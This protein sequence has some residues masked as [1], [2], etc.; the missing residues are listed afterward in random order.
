MSN[1]CMYVWL[2][3]FYNSQMLIS[4]LFVSIWIHAWTAGTE[5]YEKVFLFS[6]IIYFL[7]QTEKERRKVEGKRATLYYLASKWSIWW[8]VWWV[9]LC[10]LC[11]HSENRKR[12]IKMMPRKQ[13]IFMSGERASDLRCLAMLVQKGI[14]GVFNHVCG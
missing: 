13:H 11:Q 4:F 12:V 2:I 9:L 6:F 3:I 1:A 5:A 8:W 10:Q 14:C 7:L